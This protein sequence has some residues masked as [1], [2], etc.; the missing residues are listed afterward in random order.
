MAYLRKV[1]RVSIG[2]LH[3]TFFGEDDVELEFDDEYAINRLYKIESARNIADLFTKPL[4][5][6]A[7]WFLM[8]LIG[9][10]TAQTRGN[11]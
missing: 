6:D 11:A 9:M 3:Q 7:H 10:V 5:P 1:K 2:A 4:C 8:E